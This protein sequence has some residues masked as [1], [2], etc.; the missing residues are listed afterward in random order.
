MQN[1]VLAKR[2]VPK[3]TP[4]WSHS[5]M[6]TVRTT[7]AERLLLLGTILLLPLE[8]HIPSLGGFS[9]LFIA[10][11][12]LAAYIMINRAHQL[13]LIWRHPVF[14]SAYAFIGLSALIEL[15]SPLPSLYVIGRFGLMICGAVLV[16]TLC[17]D[18]S[19]L[20]ICLYGYIGAA[21]WLGLVIYST[22]YGTLSDITAVNAQEASMVRA[23]VFSDAP[24][25]G[26]LNR[27]AFSCV[28]GGVAAFAFALASRSPRVRW[29]CIVVTIFCLGTSF[30]MMSRAT[31]I[32]V[33]LS[34]AALLYAYGIRYGRA[35]LL[36]AIACGC[37]LLLVPNAIWSRMDVETEGRQKDARARLYEEALQR[38]PDYL[39][40]G[41]GAG[42]YYAKWGV[43]N[44]FANF[45][46]GPEI[47]VIGVHNSFLQVLMYWGITGLSAFLVLLWASYRCLPKQCGNDPMTLALLGIGLSS[48][49]RMLFSHNFEEKELSFA[50]GMLVAWRY[51]I[52]A[53]R[54][55]TLIGWVDDKTIRGRETQAQA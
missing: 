40:S 22:A 21:L 54:D 48:V 28:Q 3:G 46:S 26:N 31:P 1:R 24:I 19:A 42:N 32:T 36:G 14:I 38:L 49:I 20:T 34:C 53:K 35:L 13:D 47:H 5:T 12:V 39:I 8:N 55:R 10:F 11:A 16:A 30:L 44:G 17:R 41:V 51:W 27:M 43:D 7:R 18:R 45:S 50:L 52:W 9:I 25:Q 6:V 29:M 15:T 37:I 23:E 2:P 33:I 4:I